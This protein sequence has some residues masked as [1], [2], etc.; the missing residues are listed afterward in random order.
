MMKTPI[1]QRQVVSTRAESF[2]TCQWS[3]IYLKGKQQQHLWI[4]V[5]CVVCE[6]SWRTKEKK[7]KIACNTSLVFI[8]L[9]TGPFRSKCNPGYTHKPWPGLVIRCLVFPLYFYHKET[10]TQVQPFAEPF[11]CHHVFH[12]QAHQGWS[13]RHFLLLHDSSLKQ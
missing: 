11:N 8:S 4:M 3:A 10:H 6:Y 13:W 7:R 5:V 9:S 2:L 12:N 1:L